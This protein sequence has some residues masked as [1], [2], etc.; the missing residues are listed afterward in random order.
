MAKLGAELGL[1]PM[2]RTKIAQPPRAVCRHDDI[3]TPVFV[4]KYGPL[5]VIPGDRSR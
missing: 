4:T 2:A 1:S 3:E 5:T